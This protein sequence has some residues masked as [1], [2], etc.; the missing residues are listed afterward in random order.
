[1]EKRM[2]MVIFTIKSIQAWSPQFVDICNINNKDSIIGQTIYIK[3][4]KK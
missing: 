3:S 4:F 2:N 1:M